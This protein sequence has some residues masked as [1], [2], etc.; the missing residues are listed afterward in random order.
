MDFRQLSCCFSGDSA[1]SAY[2][3]KYG[4]GDYLLAPS[5]HMPFVSQ[6]SRGGVVGIA[7]RVLDAACAWRGDSLTR[8]RVV[9]SCRISPSIDAANVSLFALNAWWQCLCEVIRDLTNA[10]RDETP[11]WP[12]EADVSYIDGKVRENRHDV[13]V[14][15]FIDE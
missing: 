9:D 11:L 12:H 7:S 2:L 10:R 4:S 14:P 3:Y 6:A 13:R 8:W 1:F 5:R 15:Q